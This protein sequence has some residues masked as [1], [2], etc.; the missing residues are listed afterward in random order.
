M[1]STYTACEQASKVLVVDA[2]TT[3]CHSIV[4]LESECCTT[5]GMCDTFAC[6]APG[7]TH[8]PFASSTQCA[9]SPTGSFCTEAQ[10]CV[11]SLFIFAW[12]F[13]HVDVC[14]CCLACSLALLDSSSVS[15]HSPIRSIFRRT[16][17]PIK[18]NVGLRP[19]VCNVQLRCARPLPIVR[20]MAKC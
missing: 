17:F 8:I 6:P 7:K 16:L 10:C 5:V 4:C 9:S 11:E 12:A 15:M 18:T 1:C 2:A 13:V 19:F 3:A 14:C 20:R